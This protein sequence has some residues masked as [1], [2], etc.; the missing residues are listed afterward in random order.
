[1]KTK[2]LLLIILEYPAS[3]SLHEI[4]DYAQGAL[5]KWG[6]QRH[7]DDH[8]F[9]SDNLKAKKKNMVMVRLA[10]AR[11]FCANNGQL[12]HRFLVKE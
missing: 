1:M 8:L 9:P 7:P 6:G 5:E 2:K 4:K 10:R 12:V 11:Y 3:V